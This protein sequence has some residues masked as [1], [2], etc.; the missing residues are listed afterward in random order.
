[1]WITK[2]KSTSYI[3]NL[4]D[5]QSIIKWR[6]TVKWGYVE[7]VKEK[8]E[9]KVE[10]VEVEVK[11]EEEVSD[12][13]DIEKIKRWEVNIGQWEKEL[14]TLYHIPPNVLHAQ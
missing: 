2:A 6:D 14:L 13:S 1:M 4:R 5:I 12:N 3:N 9:V 8:V 10:K 7:N 11:V